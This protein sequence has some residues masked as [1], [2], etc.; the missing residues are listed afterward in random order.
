MAKR[1]GQS[2]LQRQRSQCLSHE[3][4]GKHF[5]DRHAQQ[6]AFGAAVHSCAR[7]YPKK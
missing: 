3:M 6:K 5:A 4:K 7:K 1:R 2:P